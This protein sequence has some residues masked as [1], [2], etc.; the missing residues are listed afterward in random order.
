[1]LTSEHMDSD[2]RLVSGPLFSKLQVLLE[3]KPGWYWLNSTRS[4]LII[5]QQEQQGTWFTLN[6]VIMLVRSQLSSPDSCKKKTLNWF[7]FAGMT[8]INNKHVTDSK[9]LILVSPVGPCYWFSHHV[10]FLPQCLGLWFPSAA[11]S[12]YNRMCLCLYKLESHKKTPAEEN[13]DD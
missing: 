11:A 2:R 1:M 12:L 7:F 9:Q 8:I 4:A 6:S 13:K 3:K 10:D 5:A